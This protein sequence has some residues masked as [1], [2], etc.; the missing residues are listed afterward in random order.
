[1]ESH[2][3]KS[4]NE[5]FGLELIF[6]DFR[7][8]QN[9]MENYLDNV[10]VNFEKKHD[11]KS[12]IKSEEAQKKYGNEYLMHM[13]TSYCNEYERLTLQ[14]PHDF[15]A[16]FLVQ[17]ISFIEYEL[18][19][20]CQYHHTLHNTDFSVL[21]LNGNGD[22]AKIKKYLSKAVKLDINKLNPEWGLI[23]KI[24]KLRNKLVHHQGIVS[25]SE[26]DLVEL[27]NFIQ[28]NES[29]ELHEVTLDKNTHRT[30]RISITNE[31]LN[32]KLINDAENLFKKLLNQLG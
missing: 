28:G 25:E 14:F 26:K 18:K 30:Y 22:M 31:Y 10:K 17:I 15:R 5:L 6:I 24:R 23:N 7:N 20:I 3:L 4:K 8:Y 32:D 16:S 11:I 21:D 29:I 19:A 13:V 27:N 9:L 12:L 2:I 1:M